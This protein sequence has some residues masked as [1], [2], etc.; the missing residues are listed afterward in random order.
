[1]S[2]FRGIFHDKYA[3]FRWIVKFIDL[4]MSYCQNGLVCVKILRPFFTVQGRGARAAHQTL[5][6][7]ILVRIQA[8]LP[9]RMKMKE[10]RGLVLQ[11]FV[12]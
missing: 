11:H 12:V 1:L 7:L 6:L 9:E 4:G 2:K 10:T 5:N 8:P 3:A